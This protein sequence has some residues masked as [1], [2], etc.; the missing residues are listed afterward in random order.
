MS[1]NKKNLYAPPKAVN[2]EPA[3]AQNCWREGKVLVMRVG[4]GL[5]ARGVKCDQP[6]LQPMKEK[7]LWWHHPAW[8][9]LILINIIL[10]AVVAMF[11][12]KK[13]TVAIGICDDH[14]N[15]RRSLSLVAWAFFAVSLALIFGGLHI[16]RGALIVMGALGLLLSII[17]GI[18][19]SRS[20]YPAKITNEE[21]HL[22]GCGAAFLDSLPSR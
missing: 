18:T 6:A 2:L 19:A 13:A 22:K 4:S 21:V 17:V 16:D 14:D 12:R 9:L 20:A 11:V 8:Y 15:R 7:K 3:L 10:Y 1:D 5:P